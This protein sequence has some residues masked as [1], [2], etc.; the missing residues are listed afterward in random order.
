MSWPIPMAPPPFPL[1]FACLLAAM[2][3]QLQA[4][5]CE[6]ETL[7]RQ[8]AASGTGCSAAAAIEAPNSARDR[9][10]LKRLEHAALAGLG[11]AT[12]GVADLAQA[13]G[14]S[15]RH[16]QRRL[17]LLTGQHPRVYLRELRLEA[18]ARRLL[19]GEPSGN[20]AID[21]G[22]SSQSHF[23]AC[24]KVRFGLTPGHFRARR[25]HATGSGQL[26]HV[27]PASL[28]TMPSRA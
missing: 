3:E 1:Q 9:A 15:V 24:F 20:V 14:L 4:L 17:L 13:V 16:L 7:E 28:A 2:A 19:R 22:F 21:T 8:L 11:E 10:F 12:F 23:G 26:A 25:H 18:A 5:C 27:H 6:V